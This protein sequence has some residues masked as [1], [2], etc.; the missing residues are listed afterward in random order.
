MIRD[1]KG[2]NEGEITAVLN[3]LLRAGKRVAV[4]GSAVMP[5]GGAP[6]RI[7]SGGT[8][9]FYRGREIA[10]I[11]AVFHCEAVAHGC[12]GCPHSVFGTIITGE[13]TVMAG[14]R[15]VAVIG[16]SGIYTG[17]CGPGTA[18]VIDGI[19]PEILPVGVHQGHAANA[20]VPLTG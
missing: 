3:D 18:Q 4:T 15:P 6:G 12:M 14:G 1:L 13:P 16:S 11:G 20:S 8:G 2:M 7:I 5:A 9:V 19:V 10:G 17:S